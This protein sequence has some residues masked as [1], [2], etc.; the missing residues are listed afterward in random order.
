MTRCVNSLPLQFANLIAVLIFQ[1][2]I[3]LAAIALKDGACIKDLA[4]N[5]LHVNDMFGYGYRCLCLFLQIG[6]GRQMI[7][8]YM[9]FYQP[10]Y[11]QLF[12]V[13]IGEYLV[14]QLI[15]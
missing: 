1:Q 13:N 4:K 10:V 9:G 6:R 2:A 12:I 11:N 8:M 15:G 14:C 7:G 3:K 5:F